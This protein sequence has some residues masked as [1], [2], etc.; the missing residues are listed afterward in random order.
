MRRYIYWAIVFMLAGH[1]YALAAC[2]YRAT[3]VFGNGVDNT[4]DDANWNLYTVL[5]PALIESLGPNDVDPNCV[6]IA[7]AYDSKFVNTNNKIVSTAN[8]FTQ[9]ADASV[10]LGIDFALKASSF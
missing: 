3:L 7:L 2:P 1:G 9:P 10:Q 6:D 4:W 8:L 5:D